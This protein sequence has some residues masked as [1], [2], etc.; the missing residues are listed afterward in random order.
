MAKT[1]QEERSSFFFLCAQFHVFCSIKFCFYWFDQAICEIFVRKSVWN[2]ARAILCGR[3]SKADVCGLSIRQQH[4]D[5]LAVI[6]FVWSCS[7]KV[8]ILH[9]FSNHLL[10]ITIFVQSN[11]LVQ[12]LLLWVVKVTVSFQNCIL[13]TP[14]LV[15]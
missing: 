2:S 8:L 15:V 13:V 6:G 10:A 4:N 5:G 11:T 12:F 14:W 9:C 7:A 1:S 3:V